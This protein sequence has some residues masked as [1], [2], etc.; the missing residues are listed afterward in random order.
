MSVGRAGDGDAAPHLLDASLFRHKVGFLKRGALLPARTLQDAPAVLD[1]GRV[2]AEV[3]SSFGWV[4]TPLGGVLPQQVLYSPGLA[5]PRGVFPGPADGRNIF[6]PRDLRGNLFQFFA[7]AKFPGA[8]AALDTI[9][10]VIPGHWAVAR[11]P[12]AVER[13]HVTHKWGD[14]RNR[15]Q[16]QMMGAAAPQIQGE[17][18]FGDFAAQY[19]VALLQLVEVRRQ[20]PARY[21]LDEKF[22][23]P[24]LIRRGH[25]GVR[26]LDA[27]S[28][29]LHAQRRVLAGF[30]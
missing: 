22:Q 27:L 4:Q 24:F 8:A 13:A 7:I 10:L 21:Q 20:F 6:Q 26:S 15:R 9:Q 25:D 19:G 23:E 12:V 11:F 29:A 14:A 17:A 16:Q 1:H 5:S 3:A 30:E 28:L 18:A 2:T